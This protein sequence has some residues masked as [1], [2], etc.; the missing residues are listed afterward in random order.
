[1]KYLE[2]PDKAL[3]TC[4]KA[5]DNWWAFFI[6]FFSREISCVDRKLFKEDIIAIGFL[7]FWG[8]TSKKKR[9]VFLVFMG[10]AN[11]AL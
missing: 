1:M 8:F 2:M 5:V 11:F 9:K 4:S 6:F 7:S 3:S 10:L